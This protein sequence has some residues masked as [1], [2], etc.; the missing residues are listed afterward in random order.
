MF[1]RWAALAVV[2]AL[3]TLVPRSAWAQ[4]QGTSRSGGLGQNYPNPFNPETVI[5]FSIGDGTCTD[6]GRQ[7]EVS[8]KIYNILSQQ[9]ATPKL[10]APRSGSLSSGAVGQLL[11]KLKLPCGGPYDAYWNGKYQGTDRE[12]ASGVYTVVLTVDR[13][14]TATMRVTVT[15]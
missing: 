4:Q 3:T 10:Q 14:V 11:D 1:K 13:K 5:P 6:D 7:Y 8:I 2:L 12:V 15:K 9:V